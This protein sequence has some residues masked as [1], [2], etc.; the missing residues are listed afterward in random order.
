MSEILKIRAERFLDTAKHQYQKGYFDL[1]AFSLEQAVQLFLKYSIW[2]ILG[3]FEKTHKISELLNSY[4]I[5]SKE[6]K[7][8]ETLQKE[9]EETIN[10][11]EV[12]YIES[13]YIPATFTKRQ[14]E[15]M[16]DFVEKLKEILK[17]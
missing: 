4:K 14:I 7:E 10:D 13:R 1:C 16:F 12:A 2:K 5:A 8:I 11:L 6:E 15:K 3:D 17:L 9:F